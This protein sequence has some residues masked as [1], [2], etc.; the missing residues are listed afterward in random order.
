MAE[1]KKNLITK[2]MSGQLGKQ[3]VIRYES[4]TGKTF[5]QSF[6]ARDPNRVPTDAQKIA[7]D[8]FRK[9]TDYAKLHRDEDAYVDYVKAHP[10]IRSKHA[11]AVRDALKNP[12]FANAAHYIDGEVFNGINSA[13]AATTSY[14]VVVKF[15]S[16]TLDV[17]NIKI[18]EQEFDAGY[19]LIGTKTDV[20]ATYFD[21]ATKEPGKENE[22]RISLKGMAGWTD[23]N[24]V[25]WLGLEFRNRPMNLGTVDGINPGGAPEIVE[26]DAILIVQDTIDFIEEPTT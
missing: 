15:R 26:Q 14:E 20:T 4:K 24:K 11:A 8:R 17:L 16:I 1:Y 21:S 2:G 9:A 22:W 12:V 5:A 13:D 18:W 7:Q 25:Y 23:T 6:P 19:N 3:L 10:E